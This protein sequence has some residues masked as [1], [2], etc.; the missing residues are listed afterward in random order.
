TRRL[1]GGRCSGQL[2]PVR[3][4]GSG[5]RYLPTQ[6]RVPLPAPRSRVLLPNPARF[7]TLALP[8]PPTALVVLTTLANDADA[9]ALVTALLAAR[10]VACGTPLP[11]DTSIYRWVG[12]LRGS[13][14]VGDLLQTAVLQWA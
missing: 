4:A 11:G 8:M 12:Q 7:P 14:R 2:S 6:R 3:G 1:D 5:E 9:R 10:L 13:A